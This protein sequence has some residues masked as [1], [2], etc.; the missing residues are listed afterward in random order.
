M[1]P[2]ASTTKG[3]PMSSSW[4]GAVIRIS[5]R[6]TTNTDTIRQN[7]TR[8]NPATNLA[9]SRPVLDFTVRDYPHVGDLNTVESRYH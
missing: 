7:A 9:S 4:C 8:I 6:P 2:N 1:M 3:K 5:T